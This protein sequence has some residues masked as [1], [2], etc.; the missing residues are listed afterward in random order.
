L[1]NISPVIAEQ[2]EINICKNG[3]GA[4]IFQLK[5]LISPLL[6]KPDGI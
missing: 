3:G 5:F 6:F 4:G 2:N 1:Q